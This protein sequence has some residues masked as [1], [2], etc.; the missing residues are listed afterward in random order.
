MHTILEFES[1]H[2]VVIVIFQESGEDG[3][4]RRQTGS[5][6]RK[7]PHL[8]QRLV[9]G[10]FIRVILRSEKQRCVS[11]RHTADTN[12]V[13]NCKN[14]RSRKFVTWSDKAPMWDRKHTWKKHQE[15]RLLEK[16]AQQHKWKCNRHRAGIIRGN[17]EL[18]NFRFV[19]VWTQNY[20]CT[21][22]PCY[23]DRRP[24]YGLWTDR[25]AGETGCPVRSLSV[26]YPRNNPHQYK[27]QPLKS[28][29]KSITACNT[30]KCFGSI[31]KSL[32]S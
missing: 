16:H 7:S 30:Q 3:D 2:T 18:S 17:V 13:I 9:V 32:K 27:G 10:V 19:M 25:I 22:I 8:I 21:L 24:H 5:G 15:E 6:C 4:L 23:S 31:L 26:H 14:T 20:L 28:I 1:I 11:Y 12:V 29:N